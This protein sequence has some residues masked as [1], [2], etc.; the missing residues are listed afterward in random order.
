M[1]HAIL[2]HACASS[3]DDTPMLILEDDAVLSPNFVARTRK[4]IARV[5]AAVPAEERTVLLYLGGDVMAW[6]KE[7]D[8]LQLGYG[9]PPPPPARP[10]P[11]PRSRQRAK[12]GPRPGAAG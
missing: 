8:A 4:L 5:E 11:S 7:E 12:R 1:S 9:A 6:R 10:L 3:G 2:W